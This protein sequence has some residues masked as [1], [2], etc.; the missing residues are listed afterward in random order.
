M[1]GGG[2]PGIDDLLDDTG[3]VRRAL[4]SG[5][6][7]E[8]ELLLGEPALLR[9]PAL[10]AVVRIMCAAQHRQLP[11]TLASI[12]TSLMKEI[13]RVGILYYA[14]AMSVYWT[15]GV[16]AA[17][18][19]FEELSDCDLSSLPDPW[20]SDVL[21]YRALGQQVKDGKPGVVCERIT[22]IPFIGEF[23]L[24]AVDASVNSGFSARLIVDTGAPTTVLSLD[25]VKRHGMPCDLDHP[26]FTRDSAGNRVKL[27]PAFVERMA[28]G[29]V[30]LLDTPVH[31][32]KLSGKLPF[33]GLLSPLNAFRGFSVEFE[34]ERKCLTVAPPAYGEAP[35]RS[36]NREPARQELVWSEGCPSVKTRLFSGLDCFGKLDSGAMV[37][38][39][40]VK[41]A[42]KLCLDLNARETSVA[43]TA[44][45]TMRVYKGVSGMIGV[46]TEPGIEMPCIVKDLP[47][48]DHEESLFPPMSDVLI[49]MPWFRRHRVL[50]EAEGTA[51]RFND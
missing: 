5:N 35:P 16:T 23:S 33:D 40:S 3:A 31:A 6:R 47:D 39:L 19:M 20:R 18:A 48:G 17:Y 44:T 11:E 32:L 8:V 51:M 46:G 4:Q 26:R 24:F 45:G 15:M 27:Y 13:K 49:G 22:R 21:H 25:F 42:R 29:N 37:N 50:F 43:V 7:H 38:V 9:D 41:T 34:N 1:R 12:D 30:I 2:S 36:P 28:L 10:S 14:V